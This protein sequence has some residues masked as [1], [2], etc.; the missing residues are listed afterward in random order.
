MPLISINTVKTLSKEQKTEIKTRL[1]KMIQ[2]LP[3]KEESGLMVAISC[4]CT[5]FDAGVEA[6]DA[7]FVDIRLFHES[8]FEAKKEFHKAFSDMLGEVAGIDPQHLVC[9]YI[10]L[11]NW[12]GRAG[13]FR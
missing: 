8:P 3:G 13:V 2:I 9:N 4:G 7:A 10:E 11:P 1:G 12:G 5:I 6:A